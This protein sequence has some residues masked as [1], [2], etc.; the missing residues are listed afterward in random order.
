M[1]IRLL[2]SLNQRRARFTENQKGFTLI[3]LLVV[4]III[5]ILAAIAI[6]VYLGVQNNAKDASVKSD[7]ANAK[8]AIIALQT[9]AGEMV[10]DATAIASMPGIVNYGY[11]DGPNTESIGYKVLTVAA[12]GDPTFCI[13]ATS[14]T[15]AKF[16]VT[17]LL[18]ITNDATDAA[19]TGCVFE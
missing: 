18:G 9:E 8:T 17:D 19:P 5:G 6:P 12:T 10:D 13:G 2:A 14:S 15:A 1:I 3:E 16:Y 11:T 7:L 4:V